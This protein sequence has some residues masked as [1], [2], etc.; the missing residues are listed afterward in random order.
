MENHI[1]IRQWIKNFDSGMYQSADTST[2]CSAGWYDWF[3]KDSSLARK[4][5]A[6]GKKLKQISSSKKFDLDKTYVFFKNNCPLNGKLYDDF[7]ICDIESGDVLYTIVPKSGHNSMNGLGEVW[8]SKNKF[9]C[10]LFTGK[11]PDIIVFF[12]AG[13]NNE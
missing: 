4:T 3:C 8:S 12:L 10:A 6:L 1:T 2:Q 5:S 9:E 7:R 13:D 11:W